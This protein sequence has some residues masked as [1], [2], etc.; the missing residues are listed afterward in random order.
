M[1]KEGGRLSGGEP[2]LGGYAVK[3]GGKREDRCLGVDWDLRI[4]WF[5]H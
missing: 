5:S 4:R 1:W 3:G 2:G